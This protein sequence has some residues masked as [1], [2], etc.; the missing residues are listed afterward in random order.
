MNMNFVESEALLALYRMLGLTQRELAEQV[1]ISLG[2]VNRMLQALKREGYLDREGQLTGKT[3]DLLE[4]RKPRRAVILAAG[5]GMRMV[6]V[7]NTPKALL[8]VHG[9]RLI[10][11][12]IR[13]LREA[14]VQDI[15]AVVGYRKEQF[16]YLT[17]QYGVK[18]VYNPDYAGRNNLHSLT[19]V[20]G[21]FDNCYVVPCDLWCRENPFRAHE[22]CAWYAVSKEEDVL[23]DV[24][25]NRKGELVRKSPL[26][27]GNRMVGIAYLCGGE[28]AQLRERLAEL[29]G[30]RQYAGA[31]W[32]EALYA[33]DRMTVPARVFPVG[34]AVEINTYE[35]L[36]ELDSASNNLQ[37]GAIAAIGKVFG[38][39]AEDITDIAVLKKGMTNRSF[40][41]SVRGERFI[42]RIPGEGTE[43][44]INRRQEAAVYEAIR[45][46]GLCD[47]PVYIDPDTG[48]K[49]TKFLPGVRV[50]D[51]ENEDDL[52]CC[53][54]KL[55]EFHSMR[56]Q[57]E[58]RFDLWGQIEFYES[59]WPMPESM[60]RDYAETKAA[61]LKL[62]AWVDRQPKEEYLA[63]I[64]AVCDN[65]LFADT[66]QLTDWEYA[67]L[68]DPHVD[69]AMFAVYSSFGRE[70]LDHMIDLYF[71]DACPRETRTKIY[72]YAAACGLLWSNWCE[73]KS[74]LGV[75][76]GEYSLQQYRAAK[77][78]SR[79]AA[80]EIE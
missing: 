40:L 77:E 8:E 50:C 31:F 28:A 34:K 61:V 64:D 10:E 12:L 27:T 13:Q 78:Y 65:F 20:T 73:Y 79:L 17:D 68:Q 21:W 42:M 4:S 46:K 36:R 63:H 11:R 71:D 52:R 67:G 80:K 58:H 56:L 23:S 43:K 15:C 72:C 49:I 54:A 74:S 39:S 19:L 75:E 22:L 26:E 9:E 2:L 51:P 69:L 55:K 66:I 16:E 57:V 41:F 62:K 60:Y 70:K 35:Q 30:T 33:G 48:Y 14:E 32:E 1:G 7:S 29:D 38:A 53:L 5:Y 47:D 24:R 44:L 3:L 76:F 6:P 18:L 25:V 45:G 59:L 37:A